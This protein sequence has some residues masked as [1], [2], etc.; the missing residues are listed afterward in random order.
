MAT[1][2]LTSFHALATL[3][4]IGTLVFLVTD[5]SIAQTATLFPL[6]AGRTYHV[7]F[8]GTDGSFILVTPPR[9]DGWAVVNIVSGFRGAN[10]QSSERVGLNLNLAILIQDLTEERQA[11][12]SVQS[13]KD[14][15]INDLN[16][17]AA[18]AYQYRIRPSSMGGGQGSYT[19]YSIPSKMASNENGTYVATASASSVSIMAT[20]SAN[21]NNTISVVI[22]SN[23]RLT[24][25]RYGGDFN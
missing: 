15:M 12:Q 2:K 17:I 6:K 19:G 10:L 4:L 24:G 25:W 18:N 8:L 23:G 11:A 14:A 22:D 3:V 21:A 7:E 13:N 16:N 9:A 1:I 20:S 5:E